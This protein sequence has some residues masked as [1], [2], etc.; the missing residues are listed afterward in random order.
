MA[1][2]MFDDSD[3]PG[4]TFNPAKGDLHTIE[5]LAYDVKTVGDELDELREMLLSIGKTDGVWEGE[6]AAKFQEKI[7]ELPKYLKQGHESMAACSKALRGWHS[8]LQTMQ[9][10]AKAMEADAVEERKLLE[11]KNQAVDRVNARIQQAMFRQ[12][13]EPESKALSEEANAAE[14][15]AQDA[16]RNLEWTLQNAE[17]LRKY[18]EEQAAKAE[19]AIREAAE[20]RPPDLGI[21]DK[22]TDGLKGAWDGF[23]DFLVDN[24]D[25]FSKIG[26]ALSI[27]SLATMAIPPVGAVFGAL[28]IGASALALAGYG[29][30]TA[31]GGKV[32]VMD[33]VGAGLGVLPGIGAVKGLMAGGKAARAAAVGPRLPGV[34]SHADEMATSVNVARGMAD[35]LLYQQVL[36]RAGKGLGLSDEALDVGSWTMRGTQ[37]G[38]KGIGLGLGLVSGSS[39]TKTAGAPSS[40][41]FMSAAG[42]A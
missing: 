36:L 11:Q 15:A 26:S 27:L 23:K 9:R 28:A 38:I 41:T 17:A 30:K 22:I 14:T 18:W 24:A 40:N 31:R 7:G 10:Q 34:F 37:M 13:T 39:E 2:G 8:E 33:W 21:W 5:S 20:N 3:W 16:A 6:A 42:A 29:I 19:K 1:Y 12:L 35:G 4:L 32:G 25:L